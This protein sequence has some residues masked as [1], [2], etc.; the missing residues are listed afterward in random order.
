M[1]DREEPNEVSFLDSPL[2]LVRVARIGLPHVCSFLSTYELPTFSLKSKPLIPFLLSSIAQFV[3]RLH[4]LM[5]PH[6]YM[7]NKSGY[8]LLL[9]CFMWI[10]FFKP[11]RRTKRKKMNFPLPHT[12]YNNV[13]LTIPRN[14]KIPKKLAFKVKKKNYVNPVP[15]LTE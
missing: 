7:H 6:V 1:S 3:L 11:A 14:N 10:W 9:I 8:Y 15:H 12:M 5:E 13:M 4:I 2:C